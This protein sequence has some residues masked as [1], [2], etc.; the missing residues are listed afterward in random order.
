MSRYFLETKIAK[1]LIEDKILSDDKILYLIINDNII[2]AELENSNDDIISYLDNY[3]KNKNV[4]LV[5]EL[6]EKELNYILQNREDIQI[7]EIQMGTYNFHTFYEHHPLEKTPEILKNGDIVEFKK[8]GYTT[9]GNPIWQKNIKIVQNMSNI[10][11]ADYLE[12]T[13][14]KLFIEIT[15]L[16]NE[17]EIY[18]KLNES[19][20]LHEFI[21]YE[22]KEN[23][24]GINYYVSKPYK[25]IKEIDKTK[26]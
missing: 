5:Y 11:Y 12:H 24:Q 16:P 15:N 25:K 2:R 4:K 19:G 26:A 18:A 17:D 8:I 3:Y 22:N 20:L 13:G 1:K 6:N 10:E 9:E 7:H 14:N 23:K 21:V